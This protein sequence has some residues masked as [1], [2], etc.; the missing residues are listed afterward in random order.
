MFIPRISRL[1]VVHC[2]L[3]NPN[4]FNLLSWLLAYLESGHTSDKAL[5]IFQ[6]SLAC[7]GEDTASLVNCARPS[8]LTYV[9]SFSVYVAPGRTTSAMEAPT[10]PWEPAITVID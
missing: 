7:P 6:S 8:V 5:S 2:W 4:K 1:H 9:T 3:I 10:S